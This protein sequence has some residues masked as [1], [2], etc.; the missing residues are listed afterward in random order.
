METETPSKNK[1][2]GKMGCFIALLIFAIVIIL[3]A[4]GVI[5]YSWEY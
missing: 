3:I 4:T 5:N 1:K 2:Y